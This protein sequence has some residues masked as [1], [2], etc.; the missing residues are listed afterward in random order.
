MLT[1]KEEMKE[2]IKQ[3]YKEIE[4]ELW[5][6]YEKDVKEFE[7]RIKVWQEEPVD[8]IRA[9]GRFPYTA[10]VAPSTLFRR[11][12]GWEEGWDAE[13]IN[14]SR[15][16]PLPPV[17]L[18][19]IRQPLYDTEV[20]PTIKS[21]LGEGPV[22]DRCMDLRFF[23][24]Q[25]GQAKTFDCNDTKMSVD[26]NL[27]QPGQLSNPLEFE[28]AGFSVKYLDASEED[29]AEIQRGCQFTFLHT[30]NRIWE[31]IP[32]VLVPQTNQIPQR[33]WPQEREDMLVTAEKRGDVLTRLQKETHGMYEYMV[34]EK[35]LRIRPMESFQIR[36]E[37]PKGPPRVT[38]P[39][40]ILMVMDGL[41]H[42]PY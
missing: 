5:E 28:L 6:Q 9:R 23:Q 40:N 12:E 34:G 7:I 17:E 36:L 35:M 42:C 26:T 29:I 31:Q 2:C 8:E 16:T 4:D 24:R 30:G 32:L 10:P 21:D 3:A 11:G 18:I 37:W 14:F 19:G 1:A 13:T 22:I 38:E 41:M 39:V 33:I 25:L 27:S 20:V 15:P